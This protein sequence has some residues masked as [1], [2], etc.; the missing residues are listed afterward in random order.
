MNEENE[1]IERYRREMM[2]A[3]GKSG[4]KEE[5]EKNEEQ[6]QQIIESEIALCRFEVRRYPADEP[7]RAQIILRHGE[8]MSILMITG[9]DGESVTAAAYLKDEKENW[10]V[11]VYSDGCYSV[12]EAVIEMRAGQLLKVPVR[13][14]EMP[15]SAGIFKR[16]AGM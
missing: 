7:C 2:A 12:R 13:L 4:E 10:S 9:E 5:T 8:E 15:D 14:Q 6:A 1:L 3:Y 16:T 11:S